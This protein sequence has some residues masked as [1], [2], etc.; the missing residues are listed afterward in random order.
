MSKIYESILKSQLVSYFETQK[1]FSCRQYGF[2]AGR[3]TVGATAKLIEEIVD[4]FED[5]GY[6]CASFLDLTKAFDSVNHSILL[7]KLYMYNLGPLACKLMS[8]YLSNRRQSVTIGGQQSR[9]GVVNL[10]VPQ[11][12]I[13]GPIL[14]LIFINDLPNLSNDCDTSMIL[15][16]DD[17]TVITR[18][19]SLTEAQTALDVAVDETREWFSANGL[20][21]NTSKT[22]NMTF[23]LGRQNMTRSSGGFLGFQLDTGLV[24]ASHSDSVTKRLSSV[25]FLLRRLSPTVS[26]HVLKLA[27]YGLFHGIMSYGILLWGHSTMMQKVFGV[28]RRAIRVLCGLNYR[29]EC[30]GHFVEMG[31]MT[32]PSLYILECLKYIRSEAAEPATHADFHSYNTR[33][34]ENISVTFKRLERSRNGINYYAA[35]MYNVIDRGV[36][37]LPVKSFLTIMKKHL[38]KKA[39]YSIDEFLNDTRM[40]QIQDCALLS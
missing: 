20:L 19:D 32:A 35:Q 13:L 34:R 22:I 21:L 10:G 36:R 39:Y 26:S 16:A 6:S 9:L 30:R 18:K 38:L 28:Q 31:I 7:R 5:G 8:S 37:V 11:G 1:L 27:Y 25:V 2:R 14:F 33:H 29:E 24:W 17:T 4:G 23:A 12:S 3:S 40:S 15:Y